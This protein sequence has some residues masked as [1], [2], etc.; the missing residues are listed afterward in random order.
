MAEFFQ[1]PIHHARDQRRQGRRFDRMSFEALAGVLAFE[2]IKI[3]RRV[4]HAV[5]RAA[6]R[7]DQLARQRSW[8]VTWPSRTNSGSLTTSRRRAHG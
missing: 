1:H 3:I 7:A 6:N 4:A 8:L 5:E 2:T